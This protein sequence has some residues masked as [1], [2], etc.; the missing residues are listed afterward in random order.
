MNARAMIG[1]Q[2]LQARRQEMSEQ[3]L[4]SVR[5]ISVVCDGFHRAWCKSQCTPKTYVKE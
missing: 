3:L 4:I 2:S 5:E 1:I